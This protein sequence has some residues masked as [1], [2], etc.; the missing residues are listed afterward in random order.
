MNIKD[1]G[2]NK[3]IAGR[4][5]GRPPPSPSSSKTALKL[6]IR[7]SHCRSSLRCDV[8]LYL[9]SDTKVRLT[10]KRHFINFKVFVTKIK[11]SMTKM[12]PWKGWLFR[13]V[14][15][16]TLPGLVYRNCEEFGNVY[17]FRCF[18][19]EQDGICQLF[20]GHKGNAGP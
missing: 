5:F 17:F 11:Y 13:S 3:K 6:F 20:R 1:G 15:F 18:Q 7:C 4:L 12:P 2:I 9:M 19:S 8:D 10:A 14:R 16:L